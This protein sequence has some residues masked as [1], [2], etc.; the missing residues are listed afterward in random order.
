MEVVQGLFSAV[1][2]GQRRFNPV[3]YIEKLAH[4]PFSDRKDL[5]SSLHHC[6]GPVKIAHVCYCA[7]KYPESSFHHR[8]VL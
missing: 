1:Q 4:T 8:D 7:R 3:G 5:E 2:I 6:A